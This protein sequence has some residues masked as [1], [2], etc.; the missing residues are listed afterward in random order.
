M[1]DATQP[2]LSPERREFEALY[3]RHHDEILAYCARRLDRDA[4]WDA[5][6]EVFV[7][8]W[9]RF[10][11][12]PPPDR[13]RAWLYGV[14]LRVVSNQRR[15]TARRGRLSARAGG[16]LSL[17]TGPEQQVIQHEE[18]RTVLAALSRLRPGDA[19]IL[20]LSLWE[21][22][23]LAEIAEILGVSIDATKQRLSRARKRLGVE[24]RRLERRKPPTSVGPGGGDDG[25]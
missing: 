8:A 4:A 20:R 13:R 16:V 25:A 12:M 2:T 24:Y 15:G 10:G 5:A 17:V 11:D 7:V 6:A 1:R 14:A 3:G 23:H 18:E 9:R 21:E 22:M 19:E